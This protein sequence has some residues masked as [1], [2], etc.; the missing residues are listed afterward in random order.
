MIKENEQREKELEE[1][2]DYVRELKGNLKR[3]S[4]IETP[5]LVIATNDFYASE[6]DQLDIKKNEFL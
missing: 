1:M 6:Y 2:K 3:K 5:T 4:K